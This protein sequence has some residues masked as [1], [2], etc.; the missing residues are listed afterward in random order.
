MKYIE[1]LNSG[2]SFSIDNQLFFL[3]CDFKK[4]GSR[5]GFDLNKGFAK[6]FNADDIVNP[7]QLYIMDSSNTII[8]VK[9]TPKDEIKTSNIS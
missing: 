4:N 8:P 1:E 5:L 7:I 2:D 6:W 3:T 9:E